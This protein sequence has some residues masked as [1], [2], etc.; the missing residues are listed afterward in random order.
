MQIEHHNTCAIILAG[1]AGQRVG[2]QNKGLLKFQGRALIEHVVERV[3]PQ[4]AE[5]VISANRDTEKY[6]EYSKNVVGDAQTSYQ[7]PIAGILA[8]LK[9]IQH[10]KNIAAA[11]IC[12]CDTPKLPQTLFTRLN[13]A[14]KHRGELISVAHD[15]NR[16][17]NL[18]CL[19]R[20]EAWPSLLE[21]YNNGGRAMHRW[22]NEIEL[23][24]VSFSDQ[25]EAFF[26]INVLS[27]LS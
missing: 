23:I 10:Q 20:R 8:S 22:Y 2:G 5:L 16:T 1:G 21:F 25:P 9:A 19:M 15:G 4:V 13:A 14:L 3:E 7:G 12:T 6:Q 17:Q 26:N 18:H 24:E 27:E 11:L